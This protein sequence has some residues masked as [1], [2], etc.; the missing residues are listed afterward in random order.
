MAQKTE[1]LHSV[2]TTKKACCLKATRYIFISL[3]RIPQ[4]IPYPG[5]L[6]SLTPRSHYLSQLLYDACI[7][8]H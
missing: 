7:A 2:C 5:A 1:Y 8:I 6:R 4:K 3:N